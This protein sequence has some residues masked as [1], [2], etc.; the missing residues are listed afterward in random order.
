MAATVARFPVADQDAATDAIHRLLEALRAEPDPPTTVRD[1]AAALDVHIADSLAGLEVPAL[2]TA[3]RIADLG[4]GAGFPGLVLAIALPTARID[5]IE[6]TRRKCEVIDRLA[7]AAGVA[8][9]IR[10]VSRRA[11]EWAVE[12]RGVYDVVTARA[13]APLTVIAEYAAPLLAGG[14]SLVA[15]KGARDPDEEAA[16]ERAAPQL[17]FGLP[18]IRPVTPYAASRSRHLYVYSKVTTTPEKYPRRP[19]VATRK[20]LG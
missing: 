4:A 10:A 13:L 1:P 15:W 16:A 6:A 8:D 11:E 9:R 2:R 20:P 5:L 18:E 19:G 14:G 12:H 3:A 7:A 17:G